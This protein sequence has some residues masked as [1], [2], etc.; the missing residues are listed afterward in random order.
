MIDTLEDFKAQDIVVLD[1]SKNSGFTD[2]MVIV[3]GTSTRHIASMADA[4]TEHHKAHLFGQEGNGSEW[5]CTDLGSIV[6]HIFTA[7][8]RALYN[9]EKL[10]SFTF[11]E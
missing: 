11:T 3:T 4:L 6:V 7:D 2:D 9:L 5:V 10:W 1:I 8:K